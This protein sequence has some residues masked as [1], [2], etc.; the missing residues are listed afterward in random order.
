[1]SI[2]KWEKC[3]SELDKIDRFASAMLEAASIDELLWTI[4]INIGEILQFDDCVIYLEEDGVLKQKAAYG[5]K[6]AE[7]GELFNEITIEFGNGIVGAVAKSGVAEIVPNT[8]DDE[9]YIWDEFSGKSELTV[10]ITYEGRTIA[11]IDTESS[12]VNGYSEKDKQ[13]LQ[14]IA[15]IAAPRI[16]S[17]QYCRRLQNAQIE[18][19]ESNLQ[20]QFTISQL[21]RNQESLIHSEKM[22]SVGLMVAGIAHEINNPLSFSLSNLTVMK[23]YYQSIKKM[24]EEILALDGLPDDVKSIVQL[25]DYDNIIADMKC[26][27]NETTDGMIRIKNIVADLCGYVRTKDTQKKEYDLN[28]SVG[29][30]VNLL[31]GEMNGHCQVDLNLA[32]IPSLYGNGGKINQVLMNI[33]NNAIQA[34]PNGGMIKV[35]T[36]V[37]SENANI[38]ISDEGTGIMADNI[39]DIFTPFY[40]TKPVGEGTGLGLFICYKIIKEEHEG[41]INVVSSNKN[42]TTFRITLPLPTCNHV[43]LKV[44]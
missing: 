27:V 37:D 22:A 21:K 7:Y 3:M 17:A 23:D 32:A 39:C 12:Y 43:S 10:P 15:N 31:R 38:D 24:N 14:V 41:D 6:N 26:I 1:M 8:A 25:N 30:A 44:G 42:G 13:R 19:K 35:S 4:A 33:L 36:Y 9:R 40:T 2:R 11:V 16:A 34:S 18:L 5:I 20:L 29:V 28:D